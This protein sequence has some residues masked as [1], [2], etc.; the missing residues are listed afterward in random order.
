MS[1]PSVF[2]TFVAEALEQRLQEGIRHAAGLGAAGAE[3]FVTVSR[4]RRAKVQNGHLEDL[5]A[6]KRGGLGVRVIRAGGKGFRT[7]IATTTDLPPR[8]SATSSPR[9]GN[10][11]R[12]ATR[13]PGCGRRSPPG[14][15]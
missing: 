2:R 13:T 10:S 3:A 11:A 15:R 8:I 1:D 14:S 5:T 9:P 12:W 4:S 6:S 7:G